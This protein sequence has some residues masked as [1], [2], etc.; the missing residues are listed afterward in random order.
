MITVKILKSILKVFQVSDKES[1]I[2]F[3]IKDKEG[4]QVSYDIESINYGTNDKGEISSVILNLE[5]E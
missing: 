5:E 2:Y 1:T 3:N 4:N